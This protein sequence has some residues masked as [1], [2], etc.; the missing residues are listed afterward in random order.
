MRP[1]ELKAFGLLAAFSDD[2]REALAELLEERELVDGKSAFREGAE[3]V[4][5]VLLAEGQLKL[6][7]KAHAGVLGHLLAPDHLGV[8]SLFVIGE[9]EVT[10]IAEGP[11]TIWQLS[12][13]G[14]SRLAD[15]APRA[16]YRLAEAAVADFAVL[17]RPALATLIEHKPK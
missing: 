16:A 10:A 4:G 2:D 1:E 7:T 3:A 5:L 9:R 15:D 14:L 11:C 17:I 8:A 6:K 12:R 13:S